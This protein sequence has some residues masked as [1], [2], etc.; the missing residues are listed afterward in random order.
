MLTVITTVSFWQLVD[1]QAEKFGI[2][3]DFLEKYIRDLVYFIDDTCP[4]FSVPFTAAKAVCEWKKEVL[5]SICETAGSWQ[6][7]LTNL[8]L[9][10]CGIAGWECYNSAIG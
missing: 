4:T 9:S 6:G 2:N 7:P 3:H 1:F 5:C 10:V 8:D